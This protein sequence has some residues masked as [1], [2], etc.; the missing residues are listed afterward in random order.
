MKKD[1]KFMVLSMKDFLAKNL[2]KNITKPT[3]VDFVMLLIYKMENNF[4]G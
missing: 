2:D 3:L 1:Y 4:V